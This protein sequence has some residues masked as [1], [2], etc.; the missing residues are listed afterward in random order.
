MVNYDENTLERLIDGDLS[1]EELKI[2]IAGRKDPS[3]NLSKVFS[4]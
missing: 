4:S 3:I 1:W 2:I